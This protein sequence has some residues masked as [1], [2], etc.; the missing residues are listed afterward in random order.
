MAKIYT[1]LLLSVSVL[2]FTVYGSFAQVEKS[3]ARHEGDG[4]F[5][6]LIIR[7]VTLVNSTGA[8]PYGPVDIVVEKN[9][10]TQIRQVGYP[11][12]PI[13]PKGRPQAAPGDKELNCE[14]MYL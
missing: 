1:R 10:I 14:G 8:P 4:P 9:R 2:F 3:P 12:V 13:D 7:G 11:G 5:G 6:K